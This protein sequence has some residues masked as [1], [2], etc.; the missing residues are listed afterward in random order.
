[1]KIVQKFVTSNPCF[2]GDGYIT[3]K[4]LMLHSV[5]CP[6]PDGQVWCNVYNKDV[7]AC[8]HAFIDGNNGTI[9]QILPWNHR[10]WHAAGSANDTHIGVEMAESQYISYTGGA[11]FTCSNVA[12]ARKQAQTAYNAAVELFAYLCKQYN[13]NPLTQICSHAEGNRKG[14]ASNHADPEHYWNQLGT[15]LTMDGFRKAVKA[16]MGTSTAAQQPAKTETKTETKTTANTFL[17]RVRIPDLYIRS[18]AGT[19]YPSKGFIQPSIYTIVETKK[20]GGHTW[21]KLKSGAGWIA[22]EYTV[23]IESRK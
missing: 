9:Y 1:M 13:L 7:G 23:K 3:P 20:A 8:V 5:G 18:G 14:I 10:G 15:G 16:K 21:G 17:V 2:Y 11:N 12:A 6:Q 19:N 22:L 4:G